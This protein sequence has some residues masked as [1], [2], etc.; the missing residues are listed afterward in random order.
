MRLI[1]CVLALVLGLP[2]VAAAQLPPVQVYGQDTGT[3]RAVAV[4]AS[5]QLSITCANCSGTGASA[6][7]DAAFT[8]AVNSGAP[9]MGIVTADS[10]DSGDVGVVGMLANRQLKT[11]IYN[12]SG[13]EVTSFGGGT[14]YTEADT[15]A[16]ITGTAVLFES[17]TGTNALSVVS[18]A[19]PLPVS[20][21]GSSLTVDGTVTVTDGAGA[22]NV[23]CDS[24]CGSGTQY[25]EDV[26][27]TT[28]DSTTFIS[29]IRRDTTP[30]SS[31]GTAGDYTAFS[32]DGNG[33]LYVQAVLYNSSGTE[34]TL[35]SDATEDSAAGTAGPQVM[36]RAKDFDGAALPGVVSAEGDAV[37]TAA[38]LYGVQYVMV[39]SEDGSLER[40]TSTTPMVVGDGS[41]ALNVIVDS[42]TVT[43]VST[44]TSVSQ[45]GGSA[46]PVEDAGE[47]AGGTGV[48]AM[49]VRRDSAA[50]SAGT[51]GDNATL[52]TDGLGR[53]WTRD[54]N[55]CADHARISSVAIN[56]STSGNVELV[57]LNGSDLIYVCGYSVVAGAATG[58][59]FIYGTGTACATGETDITGVWSF[60]ANG[61]IT[62]ANGGVPQFIAPAGNALCVENSG[63][64]SI[65]GHVTYVRTASP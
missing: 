23:I 9:I 26:A 11:T 44:V 35:A 27:H 56:T 6:V 50:S 57:A 15:D 17:N 31:A 38:S 3:L 55:P 58:V 63:A 4:N 22:L 46:V 2:M 47:T 10:V 34:L 16:S 30:S 51:T 13:V 64:N 33:R 36:N 39:V 8:V 32:L 18:N 24:G 20:D 61:G 53:A 41:G 60:A 45:L 42:G 19:A 25:A 54:G 59:Q 65:Q 37:T 1:P 43:T 62:Q 14:Q 28:G 48:Y 52:N 29:G 12:S 40:G 21:A 5:G 49:T 7:D